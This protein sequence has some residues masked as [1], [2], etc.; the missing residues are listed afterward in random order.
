MTVNCC[1]N[2][3]VYSSLFFNLKMLLIEL[4]KMLSLDNF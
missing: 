3:K 4:L 2:K 1:L